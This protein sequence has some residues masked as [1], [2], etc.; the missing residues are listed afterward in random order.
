VTPNL[1]FD[2]TLDG[3]ADG[4]DLAA[5][6]GTVGLNI[7]ASPTIQ[8]LAGNLLQVVEPAPAGNDQTYTLD[9]T[10]PTVAMSSATGDPTTNA[11]IPV[12]VQFSEEV[13]NFIA[14]DIVPGNAAVQN[15]L[16]VD[17]DTYT[18]NLVPTGPGVTATA[19]IAADV[20]N[21]A[22]LNGNTI[23][24][25]FSRVIVDQVSIA[26][27]T[28]TAVEGGPWGLIPSHA[29][30]PAVR[31][32]RTSPSIR[33]P[34]TASAADFTLSTTT[35]G[36]RVPRWHCGHGDFPEYRGQRRGHPN[37]HGGITQTQAEAAET[38]R[39]NVATGSGYV[40]A[41]SSE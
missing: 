26:A 8:D 17:G 35:P 15:F 19:N 9:N 1:V 28:A 2:F 37:G 31:S 29:M 13:L 6:N 7:A 27:T 34:S 14:G 10:V 25:Q 32:R 33:R 24:T 22:A 21:D 16:V 23:A 3:T 39:P 30:P 12:T 4:G 36:V 38:V 11:P 18:F 20:A 40:A 5:L 41:T